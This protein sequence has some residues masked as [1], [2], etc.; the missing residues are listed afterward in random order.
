MTSK[1]ILSFLDTHKAHY[2]LVTHKTVYTAF[3]VAQTLKTKLNAIVKSI[4]VKIDK[5]YFI[6][7]LPADKN[8]DF[9]LLTNA[10]KKS[11]G[12]VK[13]I[14]FP[15]EKEITKVFK[16]KPGTLTGFHELHNVKAII[17]K[18]I[19]KVKEIIVSGGSLTQSLRMKATE[20]LKLGTP[21]VASIGK[22][23][24]VVK[25]AKQRPV[26]KKKP[27]SAKKKRR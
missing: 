25:V 6:V 2:E 12:V 14:S 17:D 22:K 10:V 21:L 8:I 15:S 16:I 3:D 9:K 24:P 5:E 20:F 23:R 7:S 26:K 27:V 4:M 18:D 11:G 1:K 19:K 13:K